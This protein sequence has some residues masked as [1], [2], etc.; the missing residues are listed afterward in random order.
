MSTR[1]SL[2]LLLCAAL[3]FVPTAFAGTARF[4]AG[5]SGGRFGATYEADRLYTAANGAGAIGGTAST[6]MLVSYGQLIENTAYSP[7]LNSVRE[8]VS[9]YRFDL[10][11]GQYL[12]TLQ[13]VELLQNGPNLRRFSVLAEGLPLLPDFDI[14]ARFGR[15]Y[16]VTYQFAVTVA[17]GQLNVTFPASVGQSTIS[18]I[19]V[20]NLVRSARAPKT[21]AP[22]TALGGYYRNIVTW[23][24]QAETDLAGYLVSRSSAAAGPYT[25]LTP[26]PTPVS[27]FFDDAVTPFAASYYKVAA[28]D[29]FGNQS[30][31]S[32]PVAAA[33]IDRTQSTLPVY[34]LTIPPDQ[35]AIL[36]ANVEA[37]YVTADFNTV[38]TAYP[39]IG[40]RFRG[41]SSRNNQK[42]SWKVNFKKSLPFEGR[43]KLN[44]K[45]V[46]MDDSMLT[47]CLSAAQLAQAS[48]LTSACAFVHLEVNG[49]YLGV[50]SRIEEV[51]DDFFA[52]RGISP[53]GQLL[54]AEGP[55]N[56][57]FRILDDYSTAWDDHSANDD[58]YAALS[59]LVQT[60]NNT[61]DASVPQVLG[62]VVNVDAYLDYYATMQLHGDWDHVAHN[63][64]I[65]RSPDSP[66]WEVVAKDFD[67]AFYQNTMSLLQGVKTSPLQPLVSY[68][69]LTSRLL[70]VPLFR[71]WYVNKLR[72][73]LASRFSSALLAPR[74]DGMHAAITEDARR[75][76]YKR[77]REENAAFDAS[78]PPL[79]DFVAQRI[80][81]INANLASVS[82]NI[83]L[84]L[85]INE[86]LP[87]NRTG[88]ST[89]AGVR[90]PW[91]ELYNPGGTAYNLTGHYMTND[92]AQPTLW[93]FPDG[94]SV[95]AGGHLLVWLDNQPAPGE[96][97]ASFGSKPRGQAIALYAPSG[98][99]VAMLDMIA[100]RA[101]PADVSYGRRSSGAALWVRQ[102]VATP[103]AA[104]V[105]AP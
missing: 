63:Y 3:L 102:S 85:L 21:P 31:F 86:V 39:G 46:S 16:A 6:P 58:G 90:S 61:P 95:P 1:V 88:I 84:P 15:N 12:L 47:E 93:K 81:Y 64:Y 19:S 30:A 52:L 76:V 89:A 104:N 72:E 82:P 32:A 100:V 5:G 45:A 33:A 35:Y 78:T 28:V 8:G 23:P 99:G 41:A 77:S 42:K 71:Q 10:P 70:N 69:V 50:F 20:Q 17:D 4:D 59:A 25:V 9:E 80:A 40:V 36:Q 48:T 44:L 91:V 34:R 60:V 37:D 55:A 49:E 14:Y 57:N 18:A 74:I 27:R 2:T 7:L 98:S 51:D 92:P 65:Y 75:D 67:Q 73:L 43:D 56:A 29:V 87:D 22:V 94:L 26:T 68:N 103:A 24:D 83:G 79:Q 38:T 13:F 97:H 101:L 53:N 62:A 66:L 54:E 96:V 105:G 11:N